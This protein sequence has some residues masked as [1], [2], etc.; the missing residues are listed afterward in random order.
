MI[1][2]LFTATFL[3]MK[4]EAAL[5]ELRSNPDLVKDFLSIEIS[6]REML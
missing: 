5:G 4:L 3:D 6:K 1:S 2:G